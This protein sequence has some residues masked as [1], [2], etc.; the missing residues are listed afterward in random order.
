MSYRGSDDSDSEISDNQLGYIS[1]DNIVPNNI[2]SP[3]V[4]IRPARLVSINN[5]SKMSF[6]NQ[7]AGS[8]AGTQYSYS[9][10][11]IKEFLEIIPVFKGEPELVPLFIREAEK[12]INYCYDAQNPLNPRNDFLTSR[13]RTKIQ[14]EAALYLANKEINT[15]DDIK[16]SIKTAYQDK[17]D[18]ATL[19]IEMAKLEQGNLT[20]FEFYKQIQKILHAQISYANLQY[21]INEGLNNHFRRVALKTLLNGL[22]DPLGSLM[23]TKD[24]ADMETALNL[25]TNTY[26]KEINSQRLLKSQNLNPQKPKPM[27]RPQTNFMPNFSPAFGTRPTYP[28]NSNS[29]PQRQNNYQNIK[30]NTAQFNRSSFPSFVNNKPVPMSISTNNTYRP[31]TIQQGTQP[32]FHVEELF[33]IDNVP[34]ENPNEN[35]NDFLTEENDQ[36]NIENEIYIDDN[37]TPYNNFLGEIASEKDNN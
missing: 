12:V 37:Y 36:N 23:R 31:N 6:A 4:I 19:A 32:Q 28:Q 21:N 1:D 34:C 16:I 13:I 24:P 17:R 8:A 33:N 29:R 20:P 10:S 35:P 27:I 26:Q 25:L 15:W 30:P 5:N 3:K 22:K 2:E 14:G 9:L 11:E 7:T 18:D